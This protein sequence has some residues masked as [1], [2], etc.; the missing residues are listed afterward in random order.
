MNITIPQ[1]WQDYELLD[2]GEGE[3]LERWGK[4]ILR[5]PDQNAVGAK[6]LDQ[7]KWN[8]VHLHFHR[9]S[10][11]LPDGQAGNEYWEV[12]KPAPEKW[13]VSYKI[14][15]AILK[16]AIKPT[17]YKHT[18]LFPE[19]TVNW[20][21]I[22]EKISKRK[23]PHPDQKLKVLNLFA[24]TGGASVAAASAGADEVVHIDSSKGAITL[25]KEN[26]KL[27]KLKNTKIRF[28]QEDVQK[29]VEKEIKRGNKYDAIILDP[30]L[31]GRGPEGELWKIEQ[32]LPGLLDSCIKLLS[33]SP[34]FLLLNLYSGNSISNQVIEQLDKAEQISLGLKSSSGNKIL[35]CG[36]VLRT[37]FFTA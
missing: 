14:E 23:Q 28:I 18:G 26:Q 2:F 7:A 16:F 32:H 11:N 24:Y 33:D 1:K 37:S 12:K 17:K 36:D 21:W 20:E 22:I 25:A 13:S 8:D 15:G 35:N 9:D 6:S 31:Y 4:Y 29:F 34:I 3:K 10:K 5:R 27:S 19:Q 30:P